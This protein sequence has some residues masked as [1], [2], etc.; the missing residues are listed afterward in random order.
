MGHWICVEHVRSFR[1][2]PPP[3]EYIM[4]INVGDVLHPIII[5]FGREHKDDAIR[6][7]NYLVSQIHE[8]AGSLERFKKKMND[9]VSS[10][11]KK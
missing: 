9:W 10:K 11:K 5:N 2:R 1:L 7:M 6:G 4:E 3:Q 8:H